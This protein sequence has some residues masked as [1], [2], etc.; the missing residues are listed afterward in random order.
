[1]ALG[2][3]G[4][5]STNAKVR[6]EGMIKSKSDKKLKKHVQKQS[7]ERSI[8]FKHPVLRRPSLTMNTNPES[9]TSEIQIGYKMRRQGEQFNGQ[10]PTLF[11]GETLGHS[12]IPRT[13]PNRQQIL[14]SPNQ[15]LRRLSW[16]KANKSWL[17]TT[18]TTF[19][20]SDISH[21][22]SHHPKQ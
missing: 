5:F 8:W 17:E 22:K 13:S 11:K 1:M 12:R 19:D 15:T 18:E 10:P 9:K 2:V 14:M 16:R 21:F 3:N 20:I 7:A 4:P 6:E